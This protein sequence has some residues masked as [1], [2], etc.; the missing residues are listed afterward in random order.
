MVDP[1]VFDLEVIEPEVVDPEVVD[2]EV[3]D[4]KVIDP[5]SSLIAFFVSPHRIIHPLIHLNDP[6][7]FPNSLHVFSKINK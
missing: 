7:N 1:E 6:S 5:K 3:V 4:P 2:P